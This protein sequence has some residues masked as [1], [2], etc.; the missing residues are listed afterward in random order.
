[1]KNYIVQ[2]R[3]D[4]YGRLI[5]V[6]TFKARSALGAIAQAAR[7]LMRND[8]CACQLIA[9]EVGARLTPNSYAAPCAYT[10]SPA[11]RRPSAPTPW[12][13]CYQRHTGYAT[14]RQNRKNYS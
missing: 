11:L 7:V 2:M 3:I 1:M 9:T 8:E 4:A 14:Q 10:T 12:Q 6:D 5:Y 13:P